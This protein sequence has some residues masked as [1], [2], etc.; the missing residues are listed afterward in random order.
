MRAD[1]FFRKVIYFFCAILLVACSHTNNTKFYDNKGN[2]VQLDQLHGKWVIVNYWAPWCAACR[3]EVPELNNFYKNNTDKDVLM[4]GV[5]AETVDANAQD[6]AITTS[7][8]NFPVLRQDPGQNWQIP[9]VEV[10]PTTFIIDPDGQI[11]ATI[12]GASTEK[13][14][15]TILHKYKDED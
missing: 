8:I 5:D 4:Y 9:V 11:V 15:K 1:N 14:L 10:I 7:G 2:P 3:W 6:D 12:S 13:S